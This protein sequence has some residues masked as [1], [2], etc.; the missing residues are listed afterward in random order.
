[1]SYYAERNGWV[2]NGKKLN[3]RKC[4]K[5]KSSRFKETLS[6]E[7]CPDCGLECDYWGGGANEVYESM[8]ARDARIEREQREAEL[9]KYYEEEY[10]EPYED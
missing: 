5:C 8:M 10:G 4:P 1:M 9:R 7:Y 3:N 6:R 2:D